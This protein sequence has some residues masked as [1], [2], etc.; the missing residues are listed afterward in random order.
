M[1]FCLTYLFFFTG[2][3]STLV[4][5]QSIKKANEAFEIFDYF[6]AKKIYEKRLKKAPYEASLGLAYIYHNQLNPFHSLPKAWR[7]CQLA[8]S[9]WG[10]YKDK[11]KQKAQKFGFYASS[12]DSLYALIDSSW[13]LAIENSQNVSQYQDY[14]EHFPQGHFK[15]EAIVLRDIYAYKA[16]LKTNTSAAFVNFLQSYPSS[17]LEPFALQKRDSLIFSESTEGNGIQEWIKFVQTYPNNQYLP[18]AKQNIFEYYYAFQNLDSLY[19]FIE[20]FPNFKQWEKAHRRAITLGLSDYNLESYQ[21]L[22]LNYPLLRNRYLEQELTQVHHSEVF[23]WFQRGLWGAKFKDDFIISPDYSNLEAYRAGK[24]IVTNEDDESALISLNQDTLIPFKAH[25][26]EFL[27]PYIVLVEN[28][29]LEFVITDQLDTLAYG[30]NINYASLGLNWCQIEGDYYFGK[31]KLVTGYIQYKED[32]YPSLI[33]P[34]HT[35][36]TKDNTLHL[37]KD[38]TFK[39]W[40]SPEAY[41]FSTAHNQYGVKNMDGKTILKDE[42]SFLQFEDGVILAHQDKKIHFFD[43]KGKEIWTSKYNAS[44]SDISEIQ[45]NQH[46]ISIKEKGKG[47]LYIIPSKKTL[48]GNFTVYD[49]YYAQEQKQ[50]WNVYNLKREKLL[51]KLEAVKFV[52]HDIIAYKADEHIQLQHINGSL[53]AEECADVY[54]LQDFLIFEKDGLK[55]IYSLRSNKI[56]KGQIKYIMPFQE[57]F[58]LIKDVDD[59]YFLLDMSLHQMSLKNTS[60]FE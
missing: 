44:F 16:A 32:I 25:Y 36:Y 6:K 33:Y 43:A 42:W 35:I 21:K 46:L 51:S 4:Y 59:A 50:G 20:N 28:D 27:T 37:L 9:A 5:G 47:V 11:Q 53:I 41:I 17:H 31:E 54:F 24:A 15:N 14:L 19:Y 52:S 40:I 45:F 48:N 56:I 55:S 8:D 10:S 39:K 26:L 12:K 7:Q 38:S 58:A 23:P 60:D 2:C 30:N 34:T 3:F 22:I 49:Q 29:D 13:F 1:K 57:R 18:L